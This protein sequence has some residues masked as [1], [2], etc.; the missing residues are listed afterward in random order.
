[1]TVIRTGKTKVDLKNRVVTSNGFQLSVLDSQ[2][3]LMKALVTQVGPVGGSVLAELVYGHDTF[4]QNQI[5]FIHARLIEMLPEL[6]SVFV[7]QNGFY[8]YVEPE[9]ETAEVL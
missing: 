6:G 1:M 2:Y 3:K 7:H 8:S 4:S 5:Q 9:A